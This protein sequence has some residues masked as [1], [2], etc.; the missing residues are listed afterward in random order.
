MTWLTKLKIA[1]VE[2]NTDNINSLLDETP[3]FEKIEDVKEA[4]YLFKEA[5]ELL[6]GLKDETAQSME[7]LKKNMEFL[8]STQ[9]AN[10]NTLDVSS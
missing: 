2:K 7:Q 8:N 9:P 5:L 10:E 4:M 6:Y 1:I 3:N